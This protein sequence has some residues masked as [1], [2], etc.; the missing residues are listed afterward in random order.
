MKKLLLVFSFL[1]LGCGGSDIDDPYI[2][3]Y[4][5][6][7]GSYE[8][9]FWGH[10]EGDP[11]Q[12]DIAFYATTSA[13]TDGTRLLEAA[14]SLKNQ[15]DYG[16]STTLTFTTEEISRFQPPPTTPSSKLIGQEV[17]GKWTKTHYYVEDRCPDCG[18]PSV[19]PAGKMRLYSLE[20]QLSG[21]PARSLKFE[22]KTNS[23]KRY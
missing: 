20:L 23:K 18:W 12:Y 3:P 1:M 15:N 8:L 2:F 13:V 7:D 4:R 16:F 19:F 14:G 6:S 9:H 11:N 10:T 17:K 5:S 22:A 21:P